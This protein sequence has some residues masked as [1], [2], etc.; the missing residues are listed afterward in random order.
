MRLAEDEIGMG[1]WGTKDLAGERLRR[2]LLC[3]LRRESV[4][5]GG[6]AATDSSASSDTCRKALSC[7]VRN[8]FVADRSDQ[9]CRPGV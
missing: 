5:C 3:G 8:P 2:F 1:R 6:L 9:S 7:F 4:C